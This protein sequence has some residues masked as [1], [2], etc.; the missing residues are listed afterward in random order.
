MGPEQQRLT[1][2][3]RANLVAYI[4]GELTEVESQAI[5]TKL[6]HSA[7]ARREIELLEKTWVLLDHLP[8]PKA[9]E[10]FTARTLT[11]VRRLATQGLQ[12]QSTVSSGLR[13]AAR[14]VLYTL[15]SLLAF[16]LGFLLMK[17]VW[18]DPT[19]RLVRDLPIAEHLDEL[20]DVG[21]MEFL[22]EI[23]NDP[24]FQGEAD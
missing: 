15:A 9:P 1:P 18:P 17:W 2:L 22:Q 14:A 5:A 7:T 4:D 16:G 8:R 12:F 10:D 24:A 11:E 21:S 13:R 20:R 23:A 19:A 6:A 3:E